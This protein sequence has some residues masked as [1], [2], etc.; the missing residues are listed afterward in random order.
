MFY[1]MCIQ[2]CAMPSVRQGQPDSVSYQ[3]SASA[4][5]PS[6]T[7]VWMATRFKDA[8][9]LF[10]SKDT[11][12]AFFAD[13][14]NSA[15]AVLTTLSTVKPNSSNSWPA[16]ADSP[17]R[18]D[19]DHGAMQVPTY[20]RQKSGWAA[21][22]A[23]RFLQPA[24]NGLLVVGILAVE[25]VGAGHRDDAGGDAFAASAA[26]AS[27]ASLISEPVAIKVS[28]ASPAASDST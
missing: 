21:S 9:S 11:R 24:E 26:W 27:S 15:L 12:G 7:L 19:A 20:L 18:C 22:M 8:E 28:F 13:Q 4:R 2:V 17:K 14:D 25:N 16:G 5:L 23:M 10:K 3:I 6:M 1:F